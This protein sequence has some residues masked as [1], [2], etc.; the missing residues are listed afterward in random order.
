[1]RK[2]FKP[3]KVEMPVRFDI[4]FNST[5]VAAMASLLPEVTREGARSVS[6]HAKDF[7]EAYKRFRAALILGPLAADKIYG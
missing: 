6:L 5:A 2:E 3:Y 1:V 4:E 7:L